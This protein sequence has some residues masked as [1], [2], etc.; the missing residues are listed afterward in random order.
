MVQFYFLSII[1]NVLAGLIFLYGK[2]L[3]QVSGASAE[4]SLENSET[5]ESENALENSSEVK[6]NFLGQLTGLDNIT[7]RLVCGILCLFVGVLKFIS[8]YS[9]DVAVVG[10]L[11][12]ALTLLVA[13]F[14]LL[15]EYYIVTLD[16][17]DSIPLGVK[18]FCIEYRKLFGTLCLASG[19]LHFILP[20]V[21]F[22]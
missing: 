2:K 13:G 11:F 7:F 12:P 5:S 8:V 16:G 14:S 6:N 3:T 19:V 10:D 20:Q 15:I 4:I 17:E 18:D 9:G 21:M 22:L 1:F